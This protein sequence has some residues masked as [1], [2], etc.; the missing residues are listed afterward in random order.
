VLVGKC[1][2]AAFVGGSYGS[3]IWIIAIRCLVCSRIILQARVFR[4]IAIEQ[5]RVREHQ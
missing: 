4:I 2:R 5:I 3:V 1:E